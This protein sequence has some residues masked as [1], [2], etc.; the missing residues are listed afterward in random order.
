V[1]TSLE[2]RADT[3]ISTCVDCPT[4][5]IGECLRC[6]ACH[7]RHATSLAAIPLGDDDVTAPRPRH[8][9]QEV[10]GFLARSFVV[11]EL[12]GILTLGLILAVRGCFS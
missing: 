11:I 3:K 7:D 5:I 8:R 2:K 6:P 10:P 4:T 12:L 1:R 9:R